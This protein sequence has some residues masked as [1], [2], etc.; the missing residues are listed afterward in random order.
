MDGNDSG[1][2]D[3]DAFFLLFH[4]KT[5]A[6]AEIAKKR[7]K[8]QKSASISS[9]NRYTDPCCW[10]LGI[11]DGFFF[12]L[13]SIFA[14]YG[15]LVLVL[16]SASSSRYQQLSSASSI[17]STKSKMSQTFLY[18][19][20]HWEMYWI[21]FRPFIYVCSE[22]LLLHHFHTIN[23]IEFYFLLCLSLICI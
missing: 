4:L 3:N 7:G 18:E 8:R 16:A 11:G 6:A 17:I 2:G 5:A 19:T 1:G 13:P 20:E 12:S 22:A 15:L 10:P 23:L 9:S 21:N 14:Y